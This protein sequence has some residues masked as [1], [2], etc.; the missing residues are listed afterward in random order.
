[1]L[2]LLRSSATLAHRFARVLLL[3][4][5]SAAESS[6]LAARGPTALRCSSCLEMSSCPPRQRIEQ[7]ATGC[8]ALLR[9]VLRQYAEHE[10]D[11]FDRLLLPTVSTTSTRAYVRS[12]HL[13][14]AC[15]SPLRPR[16]RA[17]DDGDWGTWRFKTP[18]PLRR[19]VSGSYA[20]FFFRMLPTLALPL[21]SLSPARGSRFACAK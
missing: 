6:C 9:P 14:E 21:A 8:L 5:T 12:Q 20:A 4:S 17:L 18:D 3:P 2:S 16:A 1:M 15:A 10:S 11:V 7:F 19:A 13:F